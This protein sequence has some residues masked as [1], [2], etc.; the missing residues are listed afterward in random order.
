MNSP[1]FSSK[2]LYL[3]NFASKK[4]K[5]WL[6]IR[7][8]KIKQTPIEF[9][10]ALSNVKKILVI[11]PNTLPEV[12][13]LQKHL[14]SIK[15]KYPRC[16]LDVICDEK[17]HMVIE[18]NEYVDH[19]IFYSKTEFS[20]FTKPLMALCRHIR[21][22]RYDTTILLEMSRNYVKL[23]L[24]AFSKSKIRLGL[25]SSSETPFVNLV[26]RP[27]AKKT[28]TTEIYESLLK[29]IGVKLS[30]AT[31]KW[32]SSKSSIRDVNHF[33][34][35]N[36]IGPNHLLIGLNL[37]RNLNNQKFSTLQLDNLCNDL[38]LRFNHP[39]IGFFESNH[40]REEIEADCLKFN[41]VPFF[42][43]SVSETAAIIEKCTVV[44]SLNSTTYHLCTYLGKNCVGLFEETELEKW[45]AKSS[46]KI[47]NIVFKSL[48][49]LN[50]DEILDAI[51]GV[52]ENSPKQL[53]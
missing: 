53:F 6:L 34:S 1:V 52:L 36:K 14:M 46:D 39:I 42:T 12:L 30:T 32:K 35:E 5:R 19:G 17:Y 25:L 38:A 22:Q 29:M 4:V 7:L 31:A 33:L 10:A 3:F 8:S 24:V 43:R 50:N 41:I 51:E 28:R 27:A 49:K 47:K 16:Q 15:L 11:L 9:N 21:K 13:I 20:F 45:S 26:F 48:R 2:S 18:G 23:F 37:D 44:V 40:R